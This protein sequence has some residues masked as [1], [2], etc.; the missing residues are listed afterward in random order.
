MIKPNPR[1]CH[2]R[3]LRQQQNFHTVSEQFYSRE[4]WCYTH[5]STIDPLF[6]WRWDP[7]LEQ[8][9]TSTLGSRHAFPTHLAEA[10]N[11]EILV[12]PGLEHR[13]LLFSLFPGL[14]LTLKPENLHIGSNV[15]ANS[16][17]FG[18][19]LPRKQK[20]CGTE[21]LGRYQLYH[22]SQPIP[23]THLSS[24]HDTVAYKNPKV[25]QGHAQP[26][27]GES[28]RSSNCPGSDG[29]TGVGTWGFWHRVERLFVTL[30]LCCG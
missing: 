11:G 17:S 28:W 10:W 30:Y 7:F 18:S 24:P 29:R 23:Q 20:K 4:D 8:E 25:G 22:C 12:F 1:G 26:F 27:T 14:P 6:S 16:G 15:T 19:L 2:C 13:A 3:I 9:R 21:S 5:G